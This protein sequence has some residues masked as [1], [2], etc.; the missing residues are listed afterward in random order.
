M[1]VNTPGHAVLDIWLQT[2]EALRESSHVRDYNPGEWLT[3][4]TEAGLTISAVSHDR[5]DLEFSRW[6][7]RMRTL[8]SVFSCGPARP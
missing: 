1:D 6:I 2:V 4:F 3:F 8:T 7:E 5:L